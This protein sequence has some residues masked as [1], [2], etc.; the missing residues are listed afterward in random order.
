MAIHVGF[1]DAAYDDEAGVYD[2][3]YDAGNFTEYFG[4]FIGSGVCLYNNPDSM[5]VSV[6]NTTKKVLI[7]PGYLFI[8]GYWLKSTELYGMDFSSVPAGTYAITAELN[9]GKRAILLSYWTKADPEVYPDMLVLAYV[10]VDTNKT[11]LVEDTRGRTDICGKI[12]S[13]GDLSNKVNEALAYINTEIDRKLEDALRTLETTESNLNVALAE[14]EQEINAASAKANE[15]IA[16]AEPPQVGTIKFSASKS[17]GEGWLRCD[18][19]YITEASYP[20]LVTALGK[21][22]PSGDKFQVLFHQSLGQGISNG[23]FYGGKMWV[24]SFTQ[25]VLVGVDIQTKA[26]TRLPC[27]G[28]TYF[29]TFMT[30]TIDQPLVLS[31]VPHKVGTGARVFLAQVLKDGQLGIRGSKTTESTDSTTIYNNFLLY[32]SD[33]PSSGTL[34]MTRPL[35]II[36]HYYDPSG[37]NDSYY[38]HAIP[39]TWK[40]HIPYVTSKLVDGKEVYQ[41]IIGYYYSNYYSGGT[42]YPNNMQLVTWSDESTTALNTAYSYRLDAPSFLGRLDTNTVSSGRYFQTMQR[43]GLSPGNDGEVILLSCYSRSGSGYT[44]T[45]TVYSHPGGVYSPGHREVNPPTTGTF[46]TACGP[47]NIASSK[48]IIYDL[49]TTSFCVCWLDQVKATQV[50]HEVKLPTAARVFVDAGVY[51]KGKDMFLIFVGTGF[52]FTRGLTKDDVGYFETLDTLGTIS[53]NASI[54]HSPDENTLFIVGQDSLNQTIIAKLELNTLFDYATDGT[55][56]PHIT[57]DGVPAYIKALPDDEEG[58]TPS[59]DA[60]SL[61]GLI[62]TMETASGA[63]PLTSLFN[64]TVNAENVVHTE[65]AMTLTN[66]VTLKMQGKMSYTNDTGKALNYEIYLGWNSESTAGWHYLPERVMW[67]TTAIVSKVIP[68]GGTLTIYDSAANTVN[69]ASYAGQTMALKFKVTLI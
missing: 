45:I 33:L 66:P 42:A 68:A 58:D 21:N 36:P 16:T 38:G 1:F 15:L 17:I 14:A 35:H 28:D 52:L 34:T 46:R 20:D 62:T 32:S 39:Y 6:D 7:N 59:G 48:A 43:P 53:Q 57:A 3:V 22:Y 41:T 40:N 4:Q 60:L 56:L 19:S 61:R 18:G 67:N 49:Q 55:W 23:V 26:E 51:L 54:M 44:P 29:D 12:D 25:K 13:A 27:V 50:V 8:N 47:L 30:P 31:I 10:T 24:Y 37:S 5:L 69:L 65:S 11:L 2:R 64:V 9:L 63:L